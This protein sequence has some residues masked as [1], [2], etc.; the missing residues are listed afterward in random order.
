MRRFII[1]I[2]AI[3]VLAIP[4]VA[5]AKVQRCEASAPVNTTVTTATFTALQPKD[6]IG[7]FGNVWKHDYTVT[8]NADKTFSG[9]GTVTDNGVSFAWNE[10]ITGS[11]NADMSAV[12]FATVPVGGGATFKVTDAPYNISVPVDSTWTQNI[13]EFKI[14]TPVITSVTTST[15]GT[16]CPAATKVAGS[17]WYENPGNG[18]ANF[19]FAGYDGG[20]SA[21]D[22]GTGFY[23]DK[24]G[25]YSVKATDVVGIDSTSMKM[26]MVVTHSK[27]PAVKA[28]LVLTFIVNDAPD[29]PDYLTYE[30]TNFVAK[31]GNIL[32]G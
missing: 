24:S 1:G 2:V 9:N 29:A 13:I 7:Q 31:A 22:K 32:V 11:F 17:I 5:S 14:S 19:T 21:A 26:T 28:G 3:A 18:L 10:S 30:G 16:Q 25:Y 12:S 23:V 4:S 27:H 6:T 15:P 8:V 20:A